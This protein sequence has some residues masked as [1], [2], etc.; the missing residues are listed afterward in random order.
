M[1]HLAPATPTSPTGRQY[2]IARGDTRAVVV[3]VGGGI[4]SMTVGGR[5]LLDGYGEDEVVDAARGQPLVPWPN[6]LRDG[7]YTWQGRT[8]QVALDEPSLGNALHGLLRYAGWRCA[9]LRG[10]RVQMACVLHPRPGYPFPLDVRVTYALDGHGA[11][12]ATTRAT[13]LGERD[14]PYACGQHPYLASPTDR[15]DDCALTVGA[16]RWLPTDERRIPVGVQPVDGTDYDF[17]QG[18]GLAG[19]RMD[20]AV[21]DL[22]RDADGRA[23]VRLEAPDGAG[24]ELW[25]DETYPYVE[26][27]TG[28]TLPDQARRR[29]GLGVEPMTCPPDGLGSGEGV[30]RLTPGATAVTRWGLRA[31][32]RRHGGAT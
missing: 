29:R 3:E 32:G 22:A 14:A 12:T 24:A 7:R 30:V 16:R 18:R 8:H 27:F 26:L 31:V 15:I 19:V 20:H 23:W 9:D 1:R 5:E 4:R 25:V 21:T 6:R 17:R 10:D 28:D 11:L 13:N 2:T